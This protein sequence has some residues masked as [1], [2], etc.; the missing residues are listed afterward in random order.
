MCSH[1]QN[2]AVHS[3]S[4][5]QWDSTMQGLLGPGAG[6]GKGELIADSTS[7]LDMIYSNFPLIH[8]SVFVDY[9]HLGI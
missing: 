6:G 2:V 1:A 5:V 9:I 4:N 8:D 7:I 3:L